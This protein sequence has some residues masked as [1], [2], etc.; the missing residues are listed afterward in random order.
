MDI[1]LYLIVP[2]LIVGA[3]YGLIGMAFAV[4]YKATRVVNFALGEM[5]MLTTYT[6]FALQGYLDLG[7]VPLVLATI[8]IAGAI[9]LIV[10]ILVIRPMQSEPLFSI[11]MATIGLAILLRSLVV[12]IWG[13]LPRP[14]NTG[15]PDT[16]VNIFGVGLSYG[17][18]C[19]AGLFVVASAGVF[20]F[21][22]YSRFGL[23]MRATAS[24][25]TTAMLM[26]IRVRRVQTVAWVMSTVI[27]GLAGMLSAS[28][29]TLV[30][31]IYA[32]G[33]KGFPATILGGLDSV[34]GSTLG[35]LVIGVIE[36]LAGGYIGSGLKEIAGFVIIILVLMI[37]PW[38]L[39]GQKDIERVL[40]RNGHFQASY[41]RLVQLT[42]NTVVWRWCVLFGVALCALPFVVDAYGLSIATSICLQVVGILGLNLLVGNAGLISLGYSG[43]LAI[44]AYASTILHIDLGLPMLVTIPLG[45]VAAAL[46]G[47][48][49]GIPSLRLK[50]LYLAITTLAFAFIV[51]HGI[52]EG[53][54]LTRGS[55]G[56]LVLDLTIL[57]VDLSGTRSFYYVCLG[58]AAVAGL[59]MLNLGRSR[60]GRALLAV[61]EYD[62][63]ARAM[64]VNLWKYKLYAFVISSFYIGISGG[65]YAHYV[66]YLNVDNFSPFIGIEAIAMVIAGGLGSV[67]GSVAGVIILMLLPEL[68]RLV[69][70]LFGPDLTAVFSTNALE[71]RGVILGLVIILF[72]RFEPDGFA[73]IW[74]EAKRI[75]SQWP[76]AK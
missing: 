9:A 4:I 14:S 45:G 27:A 55:A 57:G 5:M 23:A 49:I 37:R 18:I 67:L 8:V 46:A 48:V 34:L 16:Y 43:F 31:T 3:F 68:I 29:Y 62:I 26:G 2:G 56:I 58:V 32:D 19:M 69:L 74:R 33:L 71:V 64:G 17:Q 6:A 47:L 51:N 38:G 11:V 21:F 40:M 36:N 30:P 15:L 39:F 72:L 28:I 52:V 12:L 22:R 63:A 73:G 53:G 60:I 50:G 70:G 76:Y 10:E 75:W 7:F 25:E 59:T 13:A 42:D 54:D 65:L 1:A 24:R 44:G 35:G 61:R 20:V 66:S 41:G